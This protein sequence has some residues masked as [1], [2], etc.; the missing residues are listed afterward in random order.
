[1]VSAA[2]EERDR[3]ASLRIA[4]VGLAC[5]AATVVSCGN[6]GSKF[7]PDDFPD[8]SLAPP[9]DATTDATLILGSSSYG[10][11]TTCDQA[12]M[13]RS[14]IGCDYWPTVTT[15]PV[16]SIFDFAAVVANAQ[17]IDATVTVTGPNGVNQTVTVGSGEVSK[18]YLPWVKVLKGPDCNACG[19]VPVISESITAPASAYH[20]VS[21]V[22]VTVYQF[23]ALEYQGQ[24]GPPGKDW[25]SC[26][27]TTEVCYPPDGGGPP[28]YAGCYSYTNDASLLIPSTAMTGNYRVAG[29][30]AAKDQEGSYFAVTATTNSTHVTVTLSKN[31]S[32]VGGGTIAATAAGGTLNLTMNAGDVVELMSDMLADTSDLSGSLVHADQPIQVI[33]GVQCAEQPEGYPACDHLESSMLPAETLGSDYVVAPPTSPGKSVVGHVVRF[34]GNVDGTTLTYSP[35]QP[36]GCPSTLDAGQVVTCSSV[37]TVPFEVTGSNEF[38][39]SSFQLGG[40]L[41]DEVTGLPTQDGDP[42][43]SPMVATQQYLQ[44][45]IFLAPTDYDESYIDVVG[46]PGT[47]LTLDMATVT[48]ATTAVNGSWSITRIPLKTGGGGTH[49]LGASNPVGVQV[50]GY[51]SF[52]S[53]QYP[54]GLDLTEISAPPLK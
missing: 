43:M 40:S 15:N 30:H 6:A 44:S 37:V 13:T 42:S 17:N 8:A 48:A 3:G 46:P 28:G 22:P 14:Y 36:K 12:A 34:F 10:G 35:A 33:A 47:L 9:T 50:I 11:P 45:Y 16:W 5:L 31:G 18:I 51:G 25:S 21:S 1:M 4:R 39:V 26:P 29:E 54:A 52:T 32:V 23:N 38:A 24:G 41:I 53:Y 20:L 2:S 7:Q 49:V 19:E 27:G